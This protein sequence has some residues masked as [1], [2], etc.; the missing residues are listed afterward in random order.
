MIHLTETE[1]YITVKGHAG[2]APPGQDIVCEA[3]N[4]LVHTLIASIEELTDDNPAI[5]F[6]PGLFTLDK[7]HLSK[8]AQLLTGAFL[9]GFRMIAEAY[10]EYVRA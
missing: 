10:P 2:Y 9:L 4:A 6:E 5:T 3:V 1:N 7:K 8:D